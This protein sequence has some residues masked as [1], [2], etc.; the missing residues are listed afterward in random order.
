MVS[1]VALYPIK[2]ILITMIGY[3]WF[4]YF[5]SAILYNLKF[6]IG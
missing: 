3:I 6:D 4:D 1:A 5:V 2:H